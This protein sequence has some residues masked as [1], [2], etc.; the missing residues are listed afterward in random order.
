MEK[1]YKVTTEGDCEGRTIRTLGYAK[2][3]ISD[4]QDYYENQKCYGIYVEEIQIINITSESAGN[5][6]KLIKKK[7]DLERELK[8]VNERLKY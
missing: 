6:K 3:D 8:N 2:G 4:I 5:K 7:E 1:I